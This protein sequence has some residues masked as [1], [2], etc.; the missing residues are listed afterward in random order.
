MSGSRHVTSIGLVLLGIWL[1]LGCGPKP[2]VVPQA[3][4]STTPSTVAALPSPSPPTAAI[5]TSTEVS[6][7]TTR[8]PLSGDAVLAWTVAADGAV[9]VLD[10]TYTVYQLAADSL[11]PMAQS[12]PLLKS[13][14]GATIH[15]LASEDYVFA[16]TPAI[17]ETLVLDRS[18]LNLVARLEG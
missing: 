8:E 16:S 10:E 1:L 7:G 17:S 12:L 15:L 6:P 2:T 3:G 9:Y 13:E 11:A 18:D 4:P 5:P 14:D